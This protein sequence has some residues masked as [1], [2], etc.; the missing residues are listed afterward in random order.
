MYFLIKPIILTLAFLLPTQL[1]HSTTIEPTVR[2]HN[3]IIDIP[4]I[5]GQI[6]IDA[7][8]NEPQWLSAKKVLIYTENI[9]T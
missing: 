2:V 7:S 1:V 5:S 8:L 9:S 6:F 4:K 3:E